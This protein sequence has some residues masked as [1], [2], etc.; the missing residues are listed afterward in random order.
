M[1]TP[2]INTDNQMGPLPFDMTRPGCRH[3]RRVNNIWSKTNQRIRY[4]SVHLFSQANINR[5]TTNRGSVFIVHPSTIASDDRIPSSSAPR[6]PSSIASVNICRRKTN[7]HQLDMPQ[8]VDAPILLG[9]HC[10]RQSFLGE[11]HARGQ[12]GIPNPPQLSCIALNNTHNF[13]GHRKLVSFGAIDFQCLAG[14]VDRATAL[15]R[16]HV[17]PFKAGKRISIATFHTFHTTHKTSM[18]TAGPFTST[19]KT[20]QVGLASL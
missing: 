8:G 2:A 20:F 3:S 18:V 14:M 15:P 11:T 17:H 5:S 9:M 7:N 6:P 1:P 10:R 4:E 12:G 16:H 13:T 19:K